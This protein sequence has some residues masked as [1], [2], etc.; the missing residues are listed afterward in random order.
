MD[1]V[2]PILSLASSDKKEFT[3]IDWAPKLPVFVAGNTAGVVVLAKVSGVETLS[4]GNT[5][6]QERERFDQVIKSL[7]NQD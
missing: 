5:I 1:S 3:A 7:S 6:S 2:D 4:S